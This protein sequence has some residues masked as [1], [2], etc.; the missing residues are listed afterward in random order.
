MSRIPKHRQGWW[1]H[2]IHND[3]GEQH[4][5]QLQ[6]NNLKLQQKSTCQP[7]QTRLSHGVSW[8]SHP[9]RASQGNSTNLG[10]SHFPLISMAL[11]TP[12]EL[13]SL[14]AREDKAEVPITSCNQGLETAWV[15]SVPRWNA[16]DSWDHA[17]LGNTVFWLTFYF[18]LSQRQTTTN[19]P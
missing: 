16:I 1:V 7:F 18:H 12:Q 17:Q 3:C 19:D 14:Q 4:Q 9:N 8:Q 5:G 15:H 10:L 2:V 11:F 6:L 13:G